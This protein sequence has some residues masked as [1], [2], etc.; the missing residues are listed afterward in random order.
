[1]LLSDIEENDVDE[2]DE[3]VNKEEKCLMI[4]RRVLDEGT[5]LDMVITFLQLTHDQSVPQ[6][7]DLTFHSCQFDTDSG[8]I[9]KP[10]A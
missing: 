4:V 5:V 7:A 1:M 3:E 8:T 10:K 2:D 6:T 9:V